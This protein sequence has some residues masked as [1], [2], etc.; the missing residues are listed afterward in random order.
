MPT[1]Q[2]C[3]A[4]FPPPPKVL[5]CCKPYFLLRNT[6]H[7]PITRASHQLIPPLQKSAKTKIDPCQEQLSTSPYFKTISPESIL[8]V[9]ARRFGI[10]LLVVTLAALFVVK[11]CNCTFS[12]SVN[13]GLEK[14]KTLAESM[15]YVLTIMEFALKIGKV[16]E[17]LIKEKQTRRLKRKRRKMRQRSKQKPSSS[18][19][20]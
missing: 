15:N 16:I 5:Y 19:P 4:L 11:L 6:Y 12:E 17:K 1:T 10:G 3:L 14:H 7:F 9:E 18:P 2:L 13:K 20:Q 8:V